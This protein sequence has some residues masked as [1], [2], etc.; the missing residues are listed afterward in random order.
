M[1]I[2]A[3]AALDSEKKCCTKNT[4]LDGQA[5]TFTFGVPGILL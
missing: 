5:V 2:A 1:D 3:A 4:S